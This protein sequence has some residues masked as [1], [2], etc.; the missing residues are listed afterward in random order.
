MPSVF[1]KG[2]LQLD[3]VSGLRADKVQ[4]QYVP[5]KS[6]NKAPTP[7]RSMKKDPNTGRNGEKYS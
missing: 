3:K 4:T 5:F 1:D 6:S 2:K 7:K